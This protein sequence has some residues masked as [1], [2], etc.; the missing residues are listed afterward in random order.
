MTIKSK[1]SDY[2]VFVDE[3]GDHSLVSIDP[4][5]PVF[6]L[7]LCVIAKSAYAN[8]LLPRATQL[9]LDIFGHDEIILHEHDIRRRKG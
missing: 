9:K 3:S 7:S 5:F 1:F 8:Y 2:L 6:A 4:E